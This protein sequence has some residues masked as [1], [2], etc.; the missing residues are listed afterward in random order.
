MMWQID[1]IGNIL[2]ANQLFLDFLGANT[3][4][5]LNIFDPAVVS[6]SD[7]KACRAAFEKGKKEK[8]PFSATRGLKCRNGKF[9]PYT[10]KVFSELT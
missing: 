1:N 4:D 8:E 3:V 2:T 10:A 9:Y 7:Y 5:N 6:P